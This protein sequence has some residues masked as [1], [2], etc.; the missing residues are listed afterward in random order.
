MSQTRHEP[1][2]VGRV[3][4][5]VGSP[6]VEQYAAMDVQAL[7][8]DL[9][10]HL[11][12]LEDV[13]TAGWRVPLATRTLVDRATALELIDEIRL[14]VPEQVRVA[15]L[16]LQRRERVL[17]SAH[18]E[19]EAVLASARRQALERLADRS[20]EQVAAERAAQIEKDAWRAAEVVER[21]ADQDAADSLRCLRT[22][23]DALD[24]VLARQLLSS[25]QAGEPVASA[26][27]QSRTFTSQHSRQVMLAK[28]DIEHDAA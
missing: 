2:T 23:L 6:G 27:K 19:G 16:L 25:E 1:V 14:C 18:A 26:P 11:D 3:L 5:P 13:L 8:P 7:A 22:R 4:L 15:Q 20:L 9:L 28:L 17:A 10:G 24:Q 12:Q 21:Q